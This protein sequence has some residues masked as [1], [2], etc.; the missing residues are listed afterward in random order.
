MGRL[1]DDKLARL[2]AAAQPKREM[3]IVN[4]A[5]I[6]PRR[7]RFLWWPYLPLGKVVIVAGAPGHGKSQFAA[8]LAGMASRGLLYPGDVNE[9]ARTLLLCGEDD[10]DSTVVPR[11]LAVNA[12]VRLVD[13]INV[14]TSLPGGLTSTGLIRIPGDFQVMHEWAREHHDARL[15]VMD[16][17]ASF[18]GREHNLL[19]NQDVRDALAPL[20]GIAE[21]FGI[22]IV[23]VLHLNKSESREMPNRITESHG[24]Q[25]LARSVLV[26]GPDPD[27]P[28]GAQGAKK[29]I[30]LTKANMVPRADTH[31]LRCEVRSVMLGTFTPPIPTSELV[32]LGRCSI[33]ADD[34]LLP[35]GERSTR[36]EASEWLAELIGDGWRK[37]GDV[38]KAAVSDGFHWRT[39]DRLARAQG[40]QRAKQPGVSHGP[41][42]IGAPLARARAMHPGTGNLESLESLG[43]QGTKGAQE[44]L[45][46]LEGQGTQETQGSPYTDT[47][48]A[49]ARESE[50]NGQA[51]L[52]EYRAWRDRTLGE[53]DD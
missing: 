30:A 21:T 36:L 24:F 3:E 40:Y 10:L 18:F 43:G 25:A 2:R 31:S 1:S 47:S 39:V 12:D 5:G 35:S 29:V 42:W 11:L 51:N 32:L 28:D 48:R 22:T 45:E 26:L 38:R 7:A 53:R 17:V 49:R 52:D 41:W 4:L 33:T 46:S 19:Y 34:L 37:V 15:I 13:T 50:D 23:I 6:T 14:T 8:L 9:P 44:S 20:V 27:D 16:P